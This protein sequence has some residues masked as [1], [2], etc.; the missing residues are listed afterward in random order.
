VIPDLAHTRFGPEGLEVA[1][2][3]RCRLPWLPVIVLSGHV[4]P[5]AEEDARLGRADAVLMKPQPLKDL[6]HL[7]EW[8]V[9]HRP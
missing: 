7:G 2:S 8:L 9:G 1:G 4:S 5:E 6:G 3:I